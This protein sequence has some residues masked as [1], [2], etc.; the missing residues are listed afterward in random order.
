MPTSLRPILLILLLATLLRTLAL[1]DLP[2]GWR[3]DEVIETTVHAQ[4]LRDGERPLFFIEAEGHEPLYHYL[5]ATL[6]TALGGPTLWGVRLLSVF[7]G[8]LAIAAAYRLTAQLFD[9][10]TALLVALLLAVS[11]WALIYSR[12]KVRHISTL[13]FALLAL[14]HLWTAYRTRRLAPA[15]LTGVFTGLGLYT[16]F[17]ALTVPLILL[18]FGSYLLILRREPL[19]N[20]LRLSALPLAIAALIYAPLYLAMQATS[21]SADRLTIVAAPLLNLIN[22]GDPTLLL[23]TARDTLLMFIA[24]GDPEALYNLP[25]RPVFDPVLGLLFYTLGLAPVVWAALTHRDSTTTDRAALLAGWWL[26]G[27]SPGLVTIPGGSLGHTIVTLPV[28]YILLVR[29]ADQLAAWL[30]HTLTASP[31]LTPIVLRLLNALRLPP[32]ALIPRLPLITAIIIVTLVTARDGYD[33]F[34][35][36][37]QN[38]LVRLLYRANL[39]TAMRTNPPT[40]PVL[41][42][43]GLG[44]WDVR[45]FLLETRDRPAQPRWVNPDAAWIFFGDSAPQLWLPDP[46]L[47]PTLAVSE[48]YAAPAESLVNRPTFENGWQ[49][50]G[51]SNVSGDNRRLI[52]HWLITDDYVPPTPNYGTSPEP[53]DQPYRIFLH[54]FDSQGNFVAGVDRLEFDVYTLQP[55]DIIVQLHP[56]DD[57]PEGIYT[58]RAGLYNAA[59]GRRLLT[60]D[61]HDIVDIG[62]VDFWPK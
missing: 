42:A 58:L 49:L 11:F 41:V 43:S 21:G 1:A 14:S 47:I 25:G 13:V 60:T 54:I 53:P 23:T 3:D 9:R 22:A 8:L 62:T 33:Y 50:L 51:W 31:R 28:V 59:T 44:L 7:F 16:Y 24:T 27:I 34:I 32:T 18:G 17:A 56:F 4:R 40:G 36:Y 26:A 35:R 15:I 29:A 30:H 10:R 45:A 52:L 48:F 38:D 46:T 5:S 2:P 19:P 55:N 61:G 6:I 39:H 20:I 12:T 57:I 37:P